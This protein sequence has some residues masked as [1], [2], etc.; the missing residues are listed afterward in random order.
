MSSEYDHCWNAQVAI[1]PIW[2][3]VPVLKD[4]TGVSPARLKIAKAISP[5]VGRTAVPFRRLRKIMQNQRCFAE[6]GELPVGIASSAF[7]FFQT[8]LANFSSQ[9]IGLRGLA[10]EQI[11]CR[12]IDSGPIT[13][14]CSICFGVSLRSSFQKLIALIRCC[15]CDCEI[16]IGSPKHP[17]RFFGWLRFAP[18]ILENRVCPIGGAAPRECQTLQLTQAGIP[19]PD[20]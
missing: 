18:Q 15:G 2:I 14:A 6:C 19:R 13:A 11:H 17:K 3:F 16:F 10:N 5:F 4:Q 9:L 12:G 20:R 8:L 1:D 7:H